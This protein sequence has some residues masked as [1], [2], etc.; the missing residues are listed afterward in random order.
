MRGTLML[1]LALLLMVAPTAA[2]TVITAEEVIS[3]SVLSTDVDAARATEPGALFPGVSVAS[4]TGVLDTLARNASP[5]EMAA[6]C[7]DMYAVLRD[8]GRSD[9]TVVELL[10]EVGREEQALRRIRPHWAKC[11]GSGL[12]CGLLGMVA[13]SYLVAAAVDGDVMEH[14]T[15]IGV[16]AAG[17]A[18]GGALGLITGVALSAASQKRLLADH[19]S[20]VNDLVRRVNRAVASSP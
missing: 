8:C 15:G 17:C 9:D 14:S 20:H 4:Y 16:G 12:G 1:G 11:L 2:D 5:A 10:R 18:A 13:G 6:R 19:R 3:C 7:R